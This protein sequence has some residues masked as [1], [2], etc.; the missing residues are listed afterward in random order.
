MRAG[1]L[2]MQHIR[3][4]ALLAAFFAG[5]LMA[6]APALPLLADVVPREALPSSEAIGWLL[7]TEATGSAAPWDN[8]R[9][10]YSGTV[11][12]T[13]TWYRADGTP[14]REY[15]VS[16]KADDS[17]MPIA[18]TTIK[19]TGCRV[20]TGEWNLSEDAPAVVAAIAFSPSPPAEKPAAPDKLAPPAAA[21]TALPPAPTAKAPTA[22]TRA[23]P[24]EP[25]PEATS[26][27]PPGTSATTSATASP[28]A[29]DDA[30]DDPADSTEAHSTAAAAEP[31]PLAISASLP[32]RSEE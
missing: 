1:I 14:C 11:T 13:K 29:S 31:K 5:L 12:V 3:A 8:T 24:P 6:A 10:G 7:E 27:P 17:H 28:A 30:A 4:R 21:T 18:K 25:P 22:E 19:G 23:A 32:S 9:S 16:A 15:T 26:G 20:A 2:T